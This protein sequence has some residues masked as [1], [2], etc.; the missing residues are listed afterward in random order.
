MSSVHPPRNEP[1][2]ATDVLA[3]HRCVSRLEH[4]A[5]PPPEDIPPLGVVG[6]LLLRL[7]EHGVEVAVVV[8]LGERTRGRRHDRGGP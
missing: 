8:P 5:D 3:R 4:V 1:R 2:K 7:P 6:V